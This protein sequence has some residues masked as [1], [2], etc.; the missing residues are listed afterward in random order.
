MPGRCLSLSFRHNTSLPRKLSSGIESQSQPHIGLDHH[1]I[2]SAHHVCFGVF[3]FDLRHEARSLLCTQLKPSRHDSREPVTTSE[4]GSSKAP[5]ELQSGFGPGDCQP[6]LRE[7]VSQQLIVQTEPLS[8]PPE[9]NGLVLPTAAD[10]LPIGAPVNGIDL[11]VM[12]R[13]VLG[14]LA[15]AHIP[16]LEGVVPRA[17]DQEPRV[18]GEGALIDM[19]DMT[20]EGV[21]EL[22]IADSPSLA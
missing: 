21:Y 18:R 17:R 22:A 9:P 11:V 15:R 14:E 7:D 1:F 12:A 2:P 20:A 13:Q 19:G 16:H 5:A 3:G 8:A 6:A 10:L 4:S